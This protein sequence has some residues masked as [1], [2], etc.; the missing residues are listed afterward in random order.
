MSD[1][2][3]YFDALKAINLEVQAWYTGVAE[4]NALDRLMARFSPQ[5]SMVLPTGGT[6]DFATLRDIFAQHGGHRPGFAIEITSQVV[7]ADYPCG[8][9]VT[10]CERQSDGDVTLNLRRS[11]VVFERDAHGNVLCRHLQETFY[12]DEAPP[13][14][15]M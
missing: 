2:N 5:F 13:C 3:P 6:L 1:A 14:T 4:A 15:F 9:V 11:T 8:A 12:A 10:Y 7:V